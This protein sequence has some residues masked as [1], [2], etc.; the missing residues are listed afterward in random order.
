MTAA[1]ADNESYTLF[2]DKAGELW[3]NRHSQTAG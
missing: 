2:F 3:R 1:S